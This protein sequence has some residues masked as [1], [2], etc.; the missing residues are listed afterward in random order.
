SEY[1]FNWWK[2]YPE[3]W[4]YDFANVE[5]MHPDWRDWK[6]ENFISMSNR[7]ASWVRRTLLN[8]PKAARLGWYSHKFIY[9]YCR[10]HDYVFEAADNFDLLVRRVQESTFRVHFLHT[11]RLNQ[12]LY[13]FLLAKGYPRSLIEFIPKK[14]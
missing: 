6:F 5:E 7:Y 11:E 1:T 13:E 12:D 14:D 3:R 4:F 8:Y 2:K 10:D 9:Y